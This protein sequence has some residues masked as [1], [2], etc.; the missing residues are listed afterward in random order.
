MI[1]YRWRAL[2]EYLWY[3]VP[4]AKHYSQIYLI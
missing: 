2:I 1:E 4:Y 3:A